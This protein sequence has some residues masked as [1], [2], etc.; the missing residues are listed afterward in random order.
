MILQKQI[1]SED[2]C[3]IIINN[4]EK[5]QMFEWQKS[6]R[7]YTSSQIY[8]SNE[9]IWIFD[10]L[11]DY[12]E[13][14]T[15]NKLLN[16]IERIHFHKFTIN[17]FFNKHNDLRDERLFSIGVI[18]NNDYEGGEFVLYGNEKIF[19]DKSI[20]NCYIFDAGIQHEILKVIN[21]TR[22]TLIVFI[23]KDNIIF[24]KYKNI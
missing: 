22:Y 2:E 5:L 11:K 6:D 14:E 7:K 3:N 18:L 16:N 9:T 17:D 24:K 4:T 1:F 23:K 20:G 19:I 21:G 10:K 12:F 15:N 8:K 13:H